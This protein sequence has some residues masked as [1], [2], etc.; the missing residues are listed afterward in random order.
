MDFE[1]TVEDYCPET[2]REVF[3]QPKDGSS[4]IAALNVSRSMLGVPGV[5]RQKQEESDRL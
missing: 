4:E 2:G 1:L 5:C 3:H